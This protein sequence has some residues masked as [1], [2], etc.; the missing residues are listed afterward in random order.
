MA[1]VFLSLEIDLFYLRG[2][3]RMFSLELMVAATVRLLVMLVDE[4]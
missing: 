1:L 2:T 4:L 3:G